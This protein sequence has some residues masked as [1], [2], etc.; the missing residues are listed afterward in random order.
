[1]VYAVVGLRRVGVASGCAE[2]KAGYF[3]A[4]RSLNMTNGVAPS[5]PILLLVAAYFHWSMIHLKREGM[6]ADLR[7]ILEKNPSVLPG[8]K[9]MRAVD[10]S[11]EKLF[12]THIWV[13]ALPFL[14]VWFLLFVPWHSF[15]SFEYKLFNWVYIILLGT[16]YWAL[17]VNWMQLMWCWSSFKKFLQWLERRP[18]RNAFSRLRKEISWAPLVTRPRE[19]PLFV[20]TRSRDCL[21]A[22]DTFDGSALPRLQREQH[23]RLKELLS[24]E[25][26]E[27]QQRIDA[28]ELEISAGNPVPRD[29]YGPLQWLLD[30]VAIKIIGQLEPSQWDQGDSDS[31]RRE[32][33]LADKTA[34]ILRSR[35][36][37]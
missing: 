22:L 30:S 14:L 33:D 25:T 28:I 23:E 18:G 32:R 35:W 13:P 10:E 1:M 15:R 5:V 26:V 31:L 4:Y 8:A 6:A 21:K 37:S 3:L 11:I 36:Q 29:V 12:S 7:D 16:L 24:P 27:I 19:H 34:P 9:H 2:Y 20:S 17:A